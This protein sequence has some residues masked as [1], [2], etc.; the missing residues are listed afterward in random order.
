MH[1]LGGVWL[2]CVWRSLIV[3]NILAEH[4][5][6][7]WQ[8]SLPL[9]M[10]LVAWEV[11]GVIVEGGFKENYWLDTGGDILCG[12]LGILFGF[13]FLQRLEIFNLHKS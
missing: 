4:R 7:L 13:W 11:F 12:V 2:V 3:M 10:V 6:S 5:W 9:G 1:L 8:M